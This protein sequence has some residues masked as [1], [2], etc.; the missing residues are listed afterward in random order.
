MAR[1]ISLHLV[2]LAFSFGTA[3]LGV[4]QNYRVECT[5]AGSDASFVDI[6]QLGPQHVTNLFIAQNPLR[7]PVKPNGQIVNK[8]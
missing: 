7:V 4:D 3:S 5:E 1:C 6:A 2:A 8:I